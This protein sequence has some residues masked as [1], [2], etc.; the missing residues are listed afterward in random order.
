MPLQDL[1]SAVP[2]LRIYSA[3]GRPAHMLLKKGPATSNLLPQFFSEL[4][5]QGVP[6][7][8][9]QPDLQL[10]CSGG[11]LSRG[12]DGEAV[13]VGDL[14]LESTP[15][16]ATHTLRLLLGRRLVLSSAPGSAT[17]GR[18][19]EIVPPFRVRARIT[20]SA[21]ELYEPRE[22]HRLAFEEEPA[23]A[24]V[25]LNEIQALPRL[26]HQPA[27]APPR[28]RRFSLGQQLSS[29]SLFRRDQV[30][31]APARPAGGAG[32]AGG[33]PAMEAVNAFARVGTDATIGSRAGRK[34][35]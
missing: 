18:G 12:L 27:S 13:I 7:M 1:E 17:M 26:T 16:G 4:E 11:V 2:G 28:T 25:F 21:E 19:P 14:S 34:T 9:F 20:L 31:G 10:V 3:T 33:A 8:A 30:A 6:I 5:D 22:P 15:A 29:L 35:G 23:G 32:L 24:G